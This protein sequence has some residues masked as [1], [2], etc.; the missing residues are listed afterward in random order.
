[1]SDEH[2]NLYLKEI[3]QYKP[4]TNIEQIEYLKRYQNGEDVLEEIFKHNAFLVVNVSKKYFKYLSYTNFTVMDLIQYGNIG[5]INVIKQFDFSKNV[6]FSTYAHLLI[7]Q[8]ISNAI[9]DYGKYFH[10]YDRIASKIREYKYVLKKLEIDLE[11][12]PNN[13]ELASSLNTSVKNVLLLQKFIQR[14]ELRSIE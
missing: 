11:R 8:T 12:T 7:S 1:M 5:L 10:I 3:S 2:L 4:F 13:E 9:R 14:I 6:M